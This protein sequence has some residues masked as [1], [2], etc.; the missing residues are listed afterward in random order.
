MD[1]LA[2]ILIIGFF[3]S[4]FGGIYTGRPRHGG[5]GTGLSN[6][7]YAIA[8]IVFIAFALRLISLS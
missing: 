5:G 6:L 3:A 1:A 7:L 2:F 4:A 8:A